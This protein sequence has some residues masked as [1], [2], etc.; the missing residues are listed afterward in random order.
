MEYWEYRLIKNY[1]MKCRIYPSKA[2]EE[3]ILRILRGVAKA[4]NKANYEIKN[5]FVNTNEFK[6]EDG[7]TL[8]YIDYLKVVNKD[9]LNHLRSLDDDIAYVPA[10]ALSGQSGAFMRDHQRAMSHK[11]VYKIT[12]SGIKKKTHERQP[13][14]KGNSCKP[15]AVEQTDVS[16]Y[17][18]RHPRTSYTYQLVLHGAI[19]P[20]ETNPN[21]FYIRL[22]SSQQFGEKYYVKVRGWNQDIRFGENHSWNFLEMV[23]NTKPVKVMVT[24]SRDN[25]GDYWISFSLSNVYKPMPKPNDNAVGID[26]G[27]KDIMITSD[28]IKYENKHFKKQEKKHIEQLNKQL[29]RSDGWANIE[30]RKKHKEDK[31]LKPSKRYLE[32][33]QKL[34]KVHRDIANKRKHYN[35]CITHDVVANNSMIAVET[36]D[37][38]KMNQPKNKAFNSALGDAAMGELLSMLKT[39][40][41]W[42]GRGFTEVDKFFPSS[43][44]CSCCGYIM[45][46]MP[47]NVREW[48]CPKCHTRHDRDI[49]AAKNIRWYMLVSEY[50]KTT[51]PKATFVYD[52][53]AR[54]LAFTDQKG[55]VLPIPSDEEIEKFFSK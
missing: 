11:V 25:C 36:L 22:G 47:L 49:N 39:K 46:K 9:Y 41:E 24:V 30:F 37:V 17:N 51:V 55:K 5:D 50:F 34:A 13:R 1:T 2:A 18:G 15:Y 12:K 44:R 29:S 33:E 43:K 31:S 53:Q 45:P 54:V 38:I 28:G 19:K 10:S 16:F 40:S 20:S 48:K 27:I 6:L 23:Q 7:S 26:V 8:H 3:M 32:K 42:Y 4:Y 35:D 21:V 14:T 52:S